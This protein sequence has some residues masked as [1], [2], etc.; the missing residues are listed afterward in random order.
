MHI[1][2]LPT[3]WVNLATPA[4][5]YL[6]SIHKP[7]LFAYKLTA[8]QPWGNSTKPHLLLTFC[9][10]CWCCLSPKPQSSVQNTAFMPRTLDEGKNTYISVLALKVKSITGIK[11]SSWVT[12]MKRI[13]IPKRAMVSG[14]TLMHRPHDEGK[15]KEE[16]EMVHARELNSQTD[17]PVGLTIFLT[18]RQLLHYRHLWI[19]QLTFLRVKSFVSC[20]PFFVNRWHKLLLQSARQ[21]LPH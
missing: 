2:F 8:A 18:E 5:T 21:P 6:Q 19:T 15:N 17:L 4:S 12:S 7:S 9:R 3:P 1:H 20:N 14:I 10:F 16:R 11:P 13:S